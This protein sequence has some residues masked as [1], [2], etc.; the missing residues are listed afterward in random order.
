MITYNVQQAVTALLNSGWLPFGRTLSEKQ[1]EILQR[2]QVA[3]WARFARGDRRAVLYGEY[4]LFY[5]TNDGDGVVSVRI[6]DLERIAREA[7][8]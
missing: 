4:V 6:E 7:G 8:S 1:P 5:E 3:Q 2:V